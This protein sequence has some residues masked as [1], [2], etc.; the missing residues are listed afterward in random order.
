MPEFRKNPILGISIKW[1]FVFLAIIFSCFLLITHFSSVS[2]AI[3]PY[4]TKQPERLTELYFTD[5]DSLPKTVE[6][7]KSY[8]VDFAIANHE[9]RD[10]TYEYIVT[11][12]EDSTVRTAS[13][14]TVELATGELARFQYTFK[15]EKA[16]KKYEV[17]IGLQNNG[18]HINYSSQSKF[19]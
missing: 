18:Q 13:T 16:G 11:V 2:Q 7:G 1:P 12:I 14:E 8:P 5:Y 17:V 4:I 3:E 9:G 19:Q 15:P 6:A 10:E